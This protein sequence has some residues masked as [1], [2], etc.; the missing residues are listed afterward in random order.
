MN[1]ITEITS[2]SNPRVSAAALLKEKKYR[3]RDRLFLIE[4]KK[5]F[6][7]AVSSGAQIRD[8]FVLGDMADSCASALA[9]TDTAVFKV[10]EPVFEKLST[11]K[12]PEGVI[13]T[14]KY[15]DK[16][17]DS[18]IIYNAGD[19]RES[20]L[21]LSEI[22]DPGN[23]GTILRS[24]AAFGTD[25]LILSDDCADIYNPRTLRASMGAIF[26]Q[27]TVTVTDLPGTITA[28]RQSGRTVCAAILDRSARSLC[29]IPPSENAVF[30]V[31]NEGHG[32]SREII[33]AAGNSAFIPM[34]AG[35]ESLNAAIAASVIMYER[36]KNK[37]NK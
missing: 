4:G 33:E 15:I 16:L 9:G 37:I 14:V 29:D 19:F 35:T 34:A 28:L 18:D 17:H 21:I 1:N 10:T 36:G 31:G 6:T 22:R 7:E 26:R 20:V 32:L 30:I 23:L 3:D 13:C 25:M 2:R 5:L 24:A 12:S 8:V 27:K 11:E